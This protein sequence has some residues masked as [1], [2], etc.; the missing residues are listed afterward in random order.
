MEG[1]RGGGQSGFYF[2]YDRGTNWGGPFALPLFD[3]P[4][5]GARTDYLAP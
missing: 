5:I 3:T 2:S 1:Y 4:G